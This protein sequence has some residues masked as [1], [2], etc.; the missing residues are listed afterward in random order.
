MIE[1]KVYDLLKK[2]S[3]NFSASNI[4]YSILIEVKDMLEKEIKLA[5]IPTTTTK[6]RVDFCLKYSKKLRNGRQPI[7][8]YTESNQI[9]GFQVFTDSYF[10]V[11]LVDED[12]LPIEDWST[13][14]NFNHYPNVTKLI[15]LSVVKQSKNVLT[16]KISD[17]LNEFK[18]TE[19]IRIKNDTC[20]ICLHKD[21]FTRFIRFM[22]LGNTDTIRLV[23]NNA[24]PSTYPAYVLKDNGSVGII[25]PLRDDNPEI[26]EMEVM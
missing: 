24:S 17:L 5:K 3:N 7:F 25:L 21:N 14:K 8:G 6:G 18:M 22:N 13:N 23:L 20:K 10:L 16:F 19:A 1:T 4:D 11:E 26:K 9:P 2:G 15:D 12:Q